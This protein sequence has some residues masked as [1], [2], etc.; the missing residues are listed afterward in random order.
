LAF[1]SGCEADHSSPSSAEVKEWAELYLYSPNTPLWSG[2]RLGGAQGHTAQPQVEENV[3][4]TH[5]STSAQ[6]GWRGI[7]GFIQKFPDW[8][9]GART[10][11]STALS[12]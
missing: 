5:R 8:P 7:Q 12:H 3:T 4:I 2:A 11:N 10:E 6:R 1:H 9:P